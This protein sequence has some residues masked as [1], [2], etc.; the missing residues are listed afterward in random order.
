[1][2]ASTTLSVYGIRYWLHDREIKVRFNTGSIDVSLLR[3]E[4]ARLGA[5]RRL[6]KWV[7]GVLFLVVKRP[8]QGAYRSTEFRAEVK[9]IE[10]Y[11]HSPPLPLWWVEGQSYLYYRPIIPTSLISFSHINGTS[12]P[13]RSQQFTPSWVLQVVPRTKIPNSVT[14]KRSSIQSR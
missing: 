10:L 13:E 2:W 9:W 12:A 11:L 6:M 1:M 14:K 3:R 5:T 8:R 7:P 4:Q